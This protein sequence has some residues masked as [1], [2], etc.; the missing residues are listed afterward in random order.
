MSIENLLIRLE[1]LRE[2]EFK[3]LDFQ[4]YAK[5]GLHHIVYTRGEELYLIRIR[6]NKHGEEKKFYVLEI[7]KK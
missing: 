6:N 7:Y 5:I 4:V 3:K 2:T 1:V